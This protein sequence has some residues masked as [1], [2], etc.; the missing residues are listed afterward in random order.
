MK[1]I[2]I[3]VLALLALSGCTS[4]HILVGQQ[5]PAISPSEVRL[6]LQPPA[7]YE[8]VAVLK[9]NNNASFAITSQQK[10]NKV[11]ERLRDEAA[12][13][14]ANGILLQGVEDQYS[15]SVGF[16]NAFASGG[17]IWGSGFSAATFVK[18]GSGIAI[19]VPP[20][21]DQ[22]AAVQPVAAVA[23]TA[24]TAVP[25]VQPVSMATPAIPT[26]PYEVDPAKRCD[27]CARVQIP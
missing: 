8:N 18:V 15:G 5:R 12:A 27:A 3:A 2:T 25:V 10:T 13:L 1:S 21:G 23:Q 26:A 11:V 14:G 16:G 19:H 22:V 4:S 9:S 20:G 7:V 6:Y 24:P 17:H